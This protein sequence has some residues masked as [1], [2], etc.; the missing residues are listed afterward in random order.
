MNAWNGNK[1][2]DQTLLT[3][4]DQDS[5]NNIQ[6][7]KRIEENRSCIW[8]IWW[9]LIIIVLILLWIIWMIFYIVIPMN[10]TKNVFANTSQSSKLR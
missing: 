3:Q 4:M 5:N 2:S 6:R 9:E 10:D 7:N 1:V 8:D